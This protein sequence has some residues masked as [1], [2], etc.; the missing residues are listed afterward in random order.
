VAAAC[1]DLVALISGRPATINRWRYAE[2]A[3][4][5]FVCRVDRLR[6]L[7]GVEAEIGVDQGVAETGAWYRSAGWL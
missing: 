5:G 3:A 6:E 2:L 4:D 1:G 7:L